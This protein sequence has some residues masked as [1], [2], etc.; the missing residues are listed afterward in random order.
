[1]NDNATPATEIALEVIAAAA[2]KITLKEFE[3]QCRLAP[4]KPGKS[5]FDIKRITENLIANG[6]I[7]VVDN[8]L[9][10]SSLNLSDFLINHLSAG[11]QLAWDILDKI[12]PS[13]EKTHKFNNELLT[14]IG[15]DGENFFINYLHQTI[16]GILRESIKHISLIDDSAGYDIIAPSLRN[17]AK[18][19]LIEAK[20]STRPGLYFH[21]YISRNEARIGSLNR[22]WY[23][24]CISCLNSIHSLEGYI[25]YEDI[26]ELLPT[27]N[28]TLARWE[29]ASLKIE[30]EYIRK[31]IP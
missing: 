11:N 5:F 30:K 18:N 19:M 7:R 31:N 3:L 20:T 15:L 27:D 10:L 25:L 28:S 24:A 2:S 16:P 21:F 17:P 8:R 29:S 13:G 22:N 4:V 6:T 1:M 23:I 26:V 9:I 14:K 12:D